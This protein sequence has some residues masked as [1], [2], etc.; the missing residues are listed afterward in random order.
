MGVH[1]STRN[2]FTRRRL[3]VPENSLLIGY[4]AIVTLVVLWVMVDWAGGRR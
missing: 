3:S 2:F 4:F 1:S